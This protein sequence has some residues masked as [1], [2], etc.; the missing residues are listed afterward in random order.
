MSTALN[1]TG[2]IVSVEDG[3]KAAE[4][5][6]PARKAR[7]EL[8]FDVPEGADHNAHV[9]GVAEVAKSHLHR[10]LHNTAA[11]AAPVAQAAAPPAEKTPKKT[12]AKAPAEKTKAQIEAEHL[13]ALKAAEKAPASNDDELLE[14]TP[15]PAAADE[16]DDLLGEAPAVV[17]TDKE[18]GDCVQKKNAERKQADPNWAPAKIREVIQKYAGAGKR[19]NDIPNDKRAAFIKEVEAL[20]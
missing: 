11:V 17:V 2:G 14:E 20:K 18:L 15:A 12:A 6:A 10:I 3:I 13:A 9:G 1:I 19:V 8:H 4:E 5:F 16:L 7:V